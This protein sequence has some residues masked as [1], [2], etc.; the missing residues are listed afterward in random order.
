MIVRTIRT[1]VVSAM[2]LLLLSGLTAA[3]AEDGAAPRHLTLEQAIELAGQRRAEMAGAELDVKLARLGVLRAGLDRIR[4]RVEGQWG[5]Q[6]ERLHV[7]A[8]PALCESID[9]RCQPAQRRRVLDLSASVEIPVWSGLELEAGWSRARA[10]E[11]AALARQ[12]G[13]RRSLRLEV[14]TAYWTARHAELL[15]DTARRALERRREVAGLIKARADSGLAARSDRDRAE[16]AALRQQALV[17]ELDG[18]AAQANTALASVLQ[19]EGE[20]QLADD[21]AAR[22]PILPPLATLLA[23]AEERPELAEA[24]AESVASEQAL[25]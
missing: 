12:R 3:R 1:V 13:R 2:F 5:E 22:A 24:R 18:Q 11:R 7:N 8:P 21:P 14:A 19:V 15:R 23:E 10:L 16:I 17:A 6:V 20:L 25:R 4:L 9:R